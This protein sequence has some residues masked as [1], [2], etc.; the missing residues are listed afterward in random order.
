M[1]QF[2]FCHITFYS[3]RVNNTPTYFDDD[4][5]EEEDYERYEE[6]SRSEEWY[7]YYG[8]ME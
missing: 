6:G 2:T 7:N 1:N 5:V 3:K 8:D 4:Y